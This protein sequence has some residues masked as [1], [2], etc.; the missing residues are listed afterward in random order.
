MFNIS[1]SATLCYMILPL[2]LLGHPFFERHPRKLGSHLRMGTLH[3]CKQSTLLIQTSFAHFPILISCLMLREKT[4]KCNLA[5]FS[6]LTQDL[7][8]MKKTVFKKHLSLNGLENVSEI[9]ENYKKSDCFH[10]F[11]SISAL[12]KLHGPTL[13]LLHFLSSKKFWMSKV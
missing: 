4:I 13:P 1:V 6:F 3:I 11:D 9:K 2:I 8:T 12:S 5:K 7:F 10:F